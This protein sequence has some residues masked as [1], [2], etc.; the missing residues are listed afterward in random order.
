MLKSVFKPSSI[1][2]TLFVCLAFTTPSVY[3]QWQDFTL[4]GGHIVINVEL[5]G[6]PATAILDSGA[7]INGISRKLIAKHGDE[8]K[9]YGRKAQV[10]GVYG[11]S[12]VDI[13]NE[14]PIKMFGTEMMLHDAIPSS[15][16]GADLLLGA[17]FFY[18]AIIQ[19]DYPN[20]RLRRLSKKS[21]DLRKQANVPMKRARG[22]VLPAIEV[23]S[24]GKSVW[25][26]F[27]TGNAGGVLVERDFASDSG[28][29]TES[30]ETTE[31]LMGGAFT[32]DLLLKFQKDKF[33]IGPYVL[34]DVPV[35]VLNKDNLFDIGRYR[36]EI[37]TGTR[38]KKGV[39]AK[40][41]IGYEVL[42]HFVVTIDYKA[43]KV[44]LYAP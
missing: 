21:V 30:T 44:N 42:K 23:E 12:K 35:H 20:S 31:E 2:A 3:A 29:L 15:L 19:I 41:L 11:K 7:S 5:N 16:G 4:K 27:D 1:I 34:D 9:K 14:I 22:S 10:S 36:R 26:I 13:Y 18:S 28:W 24:E 33:K 39:Q 38:I 8:F 37:Q 17:S 32:A 6:E 40:G 43:F 25:L